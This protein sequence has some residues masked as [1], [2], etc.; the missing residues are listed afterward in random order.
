MRRMQQSVLATL[1]ESAVVERWWLSNGGD[2]GQGSDGGPGGG[3]HRVGGGV[4]GDQS[5]VDL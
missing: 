4:V 3:D 1:H 5:P 2:G